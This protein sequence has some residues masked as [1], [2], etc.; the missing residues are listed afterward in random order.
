MNWLRDKIE[1]RIENTEIIN[2]VLSGQQPNELNEICSKYI[3]DTY[4][5]V[6]SLID[7]ANC[8]NCKYNIDCD[9]KETW[10]ESGDNMIRIADI[11]CCSNFE[12]KREVIDDSKRTKRV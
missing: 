4:K 1:E 9:K 8:S 7:K 12:N 6:L 3:I 2:R 10:I 5:T 11:T